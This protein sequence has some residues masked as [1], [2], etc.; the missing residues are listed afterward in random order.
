MTLK[1]ARKFKKQND[2]IIWKDSLINPQLTYDILPESWIESDEFEGSD[3]EI[4]E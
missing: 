1:E 4:V 3:F 2:V